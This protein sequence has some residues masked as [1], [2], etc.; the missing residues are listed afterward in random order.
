MAAEIEVLDAPR[1]LSDLREIIREQH[2]QISR[3]MGEAVR[4][5]IT[6]G[7]V[8]IE[9]RLQIR[10]GEWAKWFAANCPMPYYTAVFYMRLA[11]NKDAVEHARTLREA[12]QLTVGLDRPAYV[13]EARHALAEEARA[14]AANG[15]SSREI[16]ELLKVNQKTVRRWVDPEVGRKQLAAQ[17]ERTRRWKEAQKALREKELRQNLAARMQQ[18]GGGV[19]ELYEDIRKLTA[20]ADRVAHDASTKEIRAGVN[21]ALA[22]LYKANDEIVKA[23]GLA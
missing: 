4:H 6:C 10:H 2:A 5:A 1:P 19:S 20:K 14:L 3:A 17:R 11:R 16:A 21:A 22:H 7:E 13:P 9:A 8:L 12:R 15:T 18:A 23:V